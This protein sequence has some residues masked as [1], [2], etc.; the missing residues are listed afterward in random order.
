M[1]NG[2]S[3]ETPQTLR[4]NTLEK[5]WTSNCHNQPNLKHHAL[6]S[7]FPKVL[8]LHRNQK[9]QTIKEKTARKRIGAIC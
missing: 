3:H 6:S 7:Y 4:K 2:I 5:K 8:P 1:T 9:S